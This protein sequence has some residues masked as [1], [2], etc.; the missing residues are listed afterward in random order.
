MLRRLF[1]KH[2]TV[3]FGVA[4]VGLPDIKFA[5]TSD[6]NLPDNSTPSYTLFGNRAYGCAVP[7]GYHHHD[8]PFPHDVASLLR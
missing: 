2:A 6:D 4:I 7:R 5:R 3:I 1:L 8:E